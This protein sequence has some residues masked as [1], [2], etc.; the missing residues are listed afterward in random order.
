MFDQHGE[1]LGR[2]LWQASLEAVDLVGEL[3]ADEGIDCEFTRRGHLTL[4]AKPSHYS[5]M[6]TLADWLDKEIDFS[7]QLLSRGDAETAVGSQ[8]YHG[9]ILNEWSASLHPTK[10]LYGLAGAVARHGGLFV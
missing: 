2:K 7:V 1:A 10:Y 9:G 4:A 5:A 6:K 3:V 8:T